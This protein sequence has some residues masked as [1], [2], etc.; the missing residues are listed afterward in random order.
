MQLWEPGK[1]SVIGPAVI[2]ESWAK[3]G[4]KKLAGQLLCLSPPHTG[5]LHERL[6]HSSAELPA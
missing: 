1:T 2:K 5:A 6:D 3:P 4:G